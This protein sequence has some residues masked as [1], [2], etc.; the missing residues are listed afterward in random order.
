MKKFKIKIQDNIMI[1]F[2]KETKIIVGD[3]QM[4][5]EK[6]LS[7]GYKVIEKGKIT[8]YQLKKAIAR[9]IVSLLK[10]TAESELKKSKH[11]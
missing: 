4:V 1:M 7:F 2:D 8:K 3:L 11:G 6:N 9:T 10:K 5:T